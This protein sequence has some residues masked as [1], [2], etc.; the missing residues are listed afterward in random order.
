MS[1]HTKYARVLVCTSLK[2]EKL[3]HVLRVCVSQMPKV[4]ERVHLQSVHAS[5]ISF[6][7][8][9]H[10]AVLDACC[11]PA[12]CI[13]IAATASAEK[14]LLA[15]WPCREEYPCRATRTG[16]LL[17]FVCEGFQSSPELLRDAVQVSC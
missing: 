13:C 9:L 8:H 4:H 1:C 7:D 12:V 14:L 5:C 15:G 10:K 17:H 3:L 6:D 2:A 16:I 11:A